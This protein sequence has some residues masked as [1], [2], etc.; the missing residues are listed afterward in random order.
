MLHRSGSL[1]PEHRALSSNLS[2][3]GSPYHLMRKMRPY[4]IL[5]SCWQGRGMC[6]LSSSVAVACTPLHWSR[7]AKEAPVA[8]VQDC[9]SNQCCSLCSPTSS[10]VQGFKRKKGI[11]MLCPA[12]WTGLPGML[13]AYSCSACC[14]HLSRRQVVLLTLEVFG[15]A[16]G[17][18]EGS[19]HLYVS[20][21]LLLLTCEYL[22]NSWRSRN[23]VEQ[24]ENEN[25]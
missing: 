23:A 4:W 20:F 10:Y 24:R 22:S 12:A 13:G 18:K 8:G 1:G 6:S 17:H 2:G 16:L 5:P 9:L 21:P 11:F 25:Q 3:R 7:R 19:L 14:C 15:S